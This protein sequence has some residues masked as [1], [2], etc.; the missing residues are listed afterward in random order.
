MDEWYVTKEPDV[1]RRKTYVNGSAQYSENM[2]EMML[3]TI[4][5]FVSS[6]AVT[7]IQIFRVFKV[8]LLCSE[9]MM[10]GMEQTL[11]CES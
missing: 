1:R 7:S 8:I 3:I 9:L 2:V 6:V 10:G 4:P 11:L 5:S